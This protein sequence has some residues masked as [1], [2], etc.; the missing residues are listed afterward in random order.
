MSVGKL[1]KDL[2]EIIGLGQN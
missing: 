1:W 2:D